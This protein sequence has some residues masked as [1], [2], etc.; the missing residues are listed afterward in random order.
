MPLAAVLPPYS[1]VVSAALVTVRSSGSSVVVVP[2]DDEDDAVPRTI[3]TWTVE[4]LGEGGVTEVKSVPSTTRTT[5]PIPVVRSM[6][7][8]WNDDAHH[9]ARVALTGRMSRA[10]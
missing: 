8:L 1:Q 3:W 2:D 7:A 6:V 5:S 9:A 4:P 10:Y